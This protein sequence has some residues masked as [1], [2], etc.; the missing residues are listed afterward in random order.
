VIAYENMSEAQKTAVDNMRQRFQELLDTTTIMFGQI[1]Q[2]TAI[3]VEQIN[4]N[5]EAN[6]VATEQ[7]ATN[8][9]VLAERGVDQGILEQ[10]RQMGPEG[11]A[12][13]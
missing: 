5:L 3:S 13:T 11:A 2:K 9:Q 12:Q 7:W 10:L 6:R 4:A 1:E 8:L